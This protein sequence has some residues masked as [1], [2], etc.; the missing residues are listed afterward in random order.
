MPPGS[1]FLTTV[2]PKLAEHVRDVALDALVADAKG[3]CDLGVSLALRDKSKD[4]ALSRVQGEM[5]V[6]VVATSGRHAFKLVPAR[7]LST[8]DGE[9]YAASSRAGSLR[10]VA[11][12]VP[13]K[14]G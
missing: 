4:I 14:P 8:P 12:E 6:P 1:R 7:R 9:L 3:I 11:A 2:D 5:D 10:R 13:K